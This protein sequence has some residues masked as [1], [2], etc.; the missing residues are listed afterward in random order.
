[1]NN[2]ITIHKVKNFEKHKQNLIDLIF[3]MPQSGIK[4]GLTEKITHSDWNH[5][6]DRDRKYFNYMLQHIIPDFSKFIC[7]IYGIDK[8]R[9]GFKFMNLVIIIVTILIQELTWLMYY[10]LNYLTKIYQPVL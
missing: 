5:S 7:N 3:S 8:L 10:L 4:D 9:F 2:N 6:Q 1:M